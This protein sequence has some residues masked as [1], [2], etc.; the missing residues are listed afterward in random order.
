[1]DIQLIFTY[2]FAAIVVL[3]PL[4]ALYKCFRNSQINMKSKMLWALG[5]I[6]I[7]VFGALVYLLMNEV[8]V[9]R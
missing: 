8:N 7:P 1:M 4:F 9:N 3:V 5:I 6:V 2:L